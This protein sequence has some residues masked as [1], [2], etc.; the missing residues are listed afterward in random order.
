[1]RVNG[2]GLLIV[3]KINVFVHGEDCGMVLRLESNDFI[4]TLQIVFF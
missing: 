4:K 3:K 1:M 2:D